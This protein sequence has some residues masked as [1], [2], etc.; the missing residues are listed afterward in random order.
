MRA[1]LLTVGLLPPVT[2]KNARLS[3]WL[4]V[5]PANTLMRPFSTTKRPLLS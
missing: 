4:E 1:F 2:L 5:L 3:D